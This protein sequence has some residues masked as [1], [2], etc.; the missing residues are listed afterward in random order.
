MEKRNPNSHEKKEIYEFDDI[1]FG[2]ETHPIQLKTIA[3]Q[4]RNSQ[5]RSLE[6]ERQYRRQQG[7]RKGSNNNSNNNN[8]TN[9]NHNPIS[10]PDYD[11]GEIRHNS[12]EQKRQAR[13]ELKDETRNYIRVDDEMPELEDLVYDPPTRSN[14]FDFDGEY[15]RIVTR[16]EEKKHNNRRRGAISIADYATGATI[17][18]NNIN[19]N[20]MGFSLLLNA[21]LNQQSNVSLTEFQAMMQQHITSHANEMSEE[22]LREFQNRTQQA[23][24]AKPR[25]AASFIAETLTRYKYTTVLQTPNETI[26]CAVCQCDIEID[27]EVLEMP[28]GNKPHQFHTV[29]LQDSLKHSNKCPVCRFEV[30][31]SDE[32]YNENVLRKKQQKK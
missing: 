12:R 8:N 1:I 13:A 17:P 29:C 20:L 15:E 30:E 11:L 5:L 9:N 32:Q 23:Y 28:C 24:E 16:E 2:N 7:L 27:E 31:S 4:S 18:S 25:P 3:N 22:D 10:I 6:M 21:L 26:V 14:D 19:E